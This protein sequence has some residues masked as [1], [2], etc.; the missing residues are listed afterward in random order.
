MLEIFRLVGNVVLD[1]SEALSGLSQVEN[2]ATRAGEVL[3]KAGDGIQTFGKKMTMFATL[4][5]IAGLGGAIK[6]ASDLNETLSK[7]EVVFGEGTKQ[8]LEWSDNTLKSIGL[9]KMTALDMAAVYGD[10]GTAMGLTQ[11]EAQKMAM[12]MVDL[13]G[14]M[15]SFKNMRPDEIHIALTGAYTG[16][17]EALKRLGVVMTVANLEQFALKEGIKKSYKEMTQAEKIALRYDFIM[18]SAKNSVGDFA[19][20]QESAANQTRIFKES[21]KEVGANIGGI[22]LPW[23]TKAVKII[24]QVIDKFR[25]LPEKVQIVSIVIASLAAATGPLIIVFGMLISAAGTI[26]GAIGAIGLPVAAVIAGLG[27]LTGVIVSSGIVM[28]AAAKKAGVLNR[29]IKWLKD[30]FYILKLILKGDVVKAV[31]LVVEKFGVTGAE[32]RKFVFKIVELKNAFIDF[33]NRFKAKSKEAF[34]YL[35]DYVVKVSKYLYKHRADILKTMYTFAKF[36]KMFIMYVSDM[37]KTIWKIVK[38][39]QQ[40]SQTMK[41]ITVKVGQFIKDI[42]WKFANLIYSANK[43]GANFIQGFI[44]GIKSKASALKNTIK[45]IPATIKRYMGF[46]SPTADGPGKD[47]DKWSPNFMDMFINGIQ[48]KIPDLIT[49]MKKAAMTLKMQDNVDFS[50]NKSLLFSNGVA[51]SGNNINVVMNYPN[52]NTEQNYN[53]VME[54]VKETLEDW[55]TERRG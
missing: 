10:M 11:K 53:E 50:M 22:L 39:G 27:I 36:A 2:A 42:K 31:D 37:A 40:F 52:L 25:I 8:V 6:A 19:R 43:W 26:A 24:N 47:S 29:A 28:I 14:D 33:A 35:I 13:T 23:F 49:T 44:N 45:N 18:N 55:I 41:N 46:S 21:I 15:A 7:T 4:P 51:G 32:A 30:T 3:K 16:E 48:S 9:A 1:T 54:N 38:W 20:T 12:S 5:V 17:T 34:Q